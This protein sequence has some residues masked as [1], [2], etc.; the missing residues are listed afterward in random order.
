MILSNAQSHQRITELSQMKA[1]CSI[2]AFLVYA[3]S[4]CAFAFLSEPTIIKV[5]AT[6]KGS[7]KQVGYVDTWD[8][9]KCHPSKNS[10]TY[11]LD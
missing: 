10:K 6:Y 11:G 2:F 7:K 4:T 5:E 3:T 8:E 1:A 9:I